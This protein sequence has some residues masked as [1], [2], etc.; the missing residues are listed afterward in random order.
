MTAR[1]ATLRGRDYVNFDVTNT[2]A[3]AA[4]RSTR[5]FPLLTDLEVE[6]LPD[7]VWLVD[8]IAYDK[9]LIALVGTYGTFKTFLMLDIALSIA[10]GLDWNGRRVRQ[11]R[12][13]YICAEGA[14]GLKYR[15][16]AWKLANQFSGSAPIHFVPKRVCVSDPLDVDGLLL[17][18]AEV[19]PAKEVPRAVVID[20]V[21]RNMEGAENNG[22]DMKKFLHGCDSLRE[23]LGAAVFVVHHMGWEG[24]RSRGSSELPAALDTEIQVEREKPSQTVVLKNSKQKDATE[25]ADITLE[26]FPVG[27]SLVFRSVEPHT[28]QLSEKER[29]ALMTVL[30]SDGLTASVWEK[31][32]GLAAST[33]N[34]ARTRL[35]D[36]AYVRHKGTK[37]IATDAA[38]LVS[39]VPGFHE[40]SIEV[41]STA[42]EEVPRFH[43][44]LG[45]EPRN[46][47]HANEDEN[48]PLELDETEENCE[49]EEVA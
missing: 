46:L 40:G 28:S 34:R 1:D 9:G 44:P 16:Q 6:N 30:R 13:V 4:P 12:V 17:S 25:F 24:T 35:L 37:Y 10:V 41:P 38:K 39:E 32:S 45:V 3:G 49:R 47:G 29:K 33:F 43:P 27:K 36:L 15:V 18:I 19:L 5:R 26:A 21:A 23:T 7:P 42:A 2:V 8:S 20:T 31:E 48:I 11:G 14:G 22:E